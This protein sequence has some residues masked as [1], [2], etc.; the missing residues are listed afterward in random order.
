MLT[1]TDQKPQKSL[2]GDITHYHI[3]VR[4]QCIDVPNFIKIGQTVA[5]IWRFNGFQNGGHPPSWISE[6][7]FF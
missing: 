3:A 2:K 7:S 4:G 5:E 1:A 6:N